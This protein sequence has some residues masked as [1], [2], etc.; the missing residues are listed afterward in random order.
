MFWTPDASYRGLGQLYVDS[1][2]FRMRYDALDP[3]LAEYLCDALAAY[4]DREREVISQLP[5][6]ARTSS[7][8]DRET[9]I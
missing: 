5:V 8:L 7:S 4:S 9:S 1:P 6:D 3:R 2:E